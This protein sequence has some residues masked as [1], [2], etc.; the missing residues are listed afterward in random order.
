MT[1]TNIGDIVYLRGING[2]HAG[3]FAIYTCNITLA[4]YPGDPR[5]VISASTND[6]S[7]GNA[8]YFA[9]W[10]NIWEVP[11][12]VT[13]R[14]LEIRGGYYYAL[15]NNQVSSSNAYW[16]AY[17]TNQGLKPRGFSLIEDCFLHS[18]GA[19]VVKLSP[20]ADGM[21]FRRCE[22]AN[23]GLRPAAATGGSSSSGSTPDGAL[24]PPAE[25]SSSAGVSVGA[26]NGI[27][28]RNAARMV[29]Q[30]CY[31]HDIAGTGI[32][33]GGGAADSLV[34]R[35]VVEDVAVIGILVGSFNTEIQYQD[36]VENSG[37][38]ESVRATVSAWRGPLR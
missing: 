30:D 8:V 20:H 25:A 14:N 16:A 12:D 17:L 22:I 32:L 31:I 4:T 37:H 5:A 3:G 26:G 21:V 15:M 34:E 28:N 35:T 29:V 10:G 9:Q 38:H 36:V 1:L 6:P 33:M 18:A 7:I 11:A 19:S 27:D 13:L 23:S 24:Q 2:P